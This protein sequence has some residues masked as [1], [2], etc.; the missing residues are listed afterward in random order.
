MES[1]FNRPFGRTSNQDS[2]APDRDANCCQGMRFAWCSIS[3]TTIRSLE[4]NANREPDGALLIEYV[5]KFID[6][7]ALFVKTI[8]SD[9]APKKLATFSRA[10]SYASVASSAN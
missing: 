8:S 9:L 6:S 1:R 3:V 4:V 7:V 5:I 2:F 10:P